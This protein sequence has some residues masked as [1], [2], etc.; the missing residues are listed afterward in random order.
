MFI[1]VDIKGEKE[2]RMETVCSVSKMAN[3]TKSGSIS[4]VSF[5]STTPSMGELLF[6]PSLPL[7]YT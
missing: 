1:K 3:T 2:E 7:F 6:P 5:Y 4:F